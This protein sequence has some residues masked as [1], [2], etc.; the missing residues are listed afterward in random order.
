MTNEIKKLY[1]NAGLD[2]LWV[3]RYTDSNGFEHENWYPSYKAM[4]KSMMEKNDW[5]LTEARNVAKKE[6]HKELLPFTAEKQIFLLQWLLDRTDLYLHRHKTDFT[7][8][9]ASGNIAV[10]KYKDFEESIAEF[11][12]A[13][14]SLLS[15]EEK[16]QVKGILE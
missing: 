5:T 3:E 6:C 7:Y 10:N 8:S 4:I 2:N 9:I 15:D 11:M 13:T 1:K 12:N 14:W 16:Q